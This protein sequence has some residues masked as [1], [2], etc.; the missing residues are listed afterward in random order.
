MKFLPKR[1]LEEFFLYS[2]QFVLFFVL[3]LFSSPS[4]IRPDTA[5]LVSLIVFLLAQI[6][7]L[8]RFGH[9]P[10]ARFL[11]SLMTPLG[12]TV[13]QSLSGPARPVDMASFFLWV[14]A[15][16][17]GG[18]QALAIMFRRKW[19]KRIA[20]IFLSL[21]TI[22]TFIFFYFYLDL[23]LTSTS[24]YESGVLGY[25]G[26]IASLS[27]SN[28][29]PAFLLFVRRIQH[30]FFMFGAL[31]FGSFQVA[32]KIKQVSLKSRLDQVFAV[33]EPPVA[34]VSMRDMVAGGETRDVVIVYADL[35]NFTPIAEKEGARATIGLLNRYYALWD[36]VARKHNG[37]VEQFVGDTAIL[38]F[39][40][41]GEKDA[42][43]E[44]VACAF[45][46]LYEFSHLQEDLAEHRLPL[47][48]HIG[49]G[50]NAGKVAVGELS[51]ASGV[52]RIGVVGEAVNV[53]AR[54]DSLCREFKQDLLVSQPVYKQLSLEPQSRFQP[55]GEVLL[56][57]KTQPQIVYGKK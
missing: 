31:M 17:L 18:I 39:G 44:A 25:E 54:L 3:I 28:F 11:F 52:Q 43:D 30:V 8:A 50:V 23:R 27:L 47:V 37:L 14:T 32:D 5:A 53:A 42:A 45:D 57:G 48:K 36:I 6:G 13:M 35:W 7:L 24:A 4:V 21:G 9:R 10:P 20:E 41:M 38:V 2:S 46:F 55:M 15:L 33:V 49:I 40:L 1:Y 26:L 51:S 29:V 19:A 22:F 12:Y 56:R 34:D 16:Y